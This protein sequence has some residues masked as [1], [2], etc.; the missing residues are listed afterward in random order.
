VFFFPPIFEGVGCWV[1]LGGEGWF[2]MTELLV[3]IGLM[4]NK[5]ELSLREAIPIKLTIF[6]TLSKTFFNHKG[7]FQSQRNFKTGSVS[8]NPYFKNHH[9]K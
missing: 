8:H 2:F 4:Q 7:R 5:L 9:I 6:R 1:E 3:E